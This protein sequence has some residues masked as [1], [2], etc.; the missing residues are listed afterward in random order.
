MFDESFRQILGDRNIVIYG[1]SLEKNYTVFW[2]V[3]YIRQIGFYDCFEGYCTSDILQSNVYNNKTVYEMV[4]LNKE[5][6]L[7]LVV[8]SN[9]TSDYI[10]EI[11]DKGFE[12]NIDYILVPDNYHEIR[13]LSTY[14][15]ISEHVALDDKRV[16]DL[17]C[18]AGNLVRT[19]ASS[20]SVEY[21]A[22]VDL[23]VKQNE[24]GENYEIR[25]ANAHELPYD[26][27]SFD[28]I[29]SYSTFEHIHDIEKTLLEVKR[30]LKPRGVF[31]NT[32][33]C[34]WTSV[35]GHHFKQK[36]TSHWN[37]EHFSLIP[38]WGH[39]YMNKHE[40]QKY[41][42]KQTNDDELIKQIINVIYD[43]DFI[44]RR[45]RRYFISAVM[46]SGMI[47]RSYTESCVFNRFFMWGESKSE[48]T[49]D[50]SRKCIT[51]GYDVTDLGIGCIKFLLEKYESM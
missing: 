5:K 44:N 7:L 19:I 36:G 37:R 13:N 21:I 20:A 29:Y 14:Q 11:S 2:L 45:S 41:L 6:H 16:L 48:L 12:K 27:N 30:V 50:I 10:K 18:G 39:L 31:F 17:C 46:N 51:A 40:M 38:A 15:T 49:L 47:V 3:R 33:G 43:S 25:H 24:T 32:F 8:S 1:E 26:D 9:E 34:L 35:W 4:K 28:C 22:G 23:T 42:Y